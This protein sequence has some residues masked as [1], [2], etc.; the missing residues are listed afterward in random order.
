MGQSILLVV[1]ISQ[2]EEFSTVMKEAGTLCVPLIL[3]WKR[4]EQSVQLWAITEENL[5]KHVSVYIAT[6]LWYILL[7]TS[8]FVGGPNPSLPLKIQCESDHEN[9][10]NCHMLPRNN[11]SQCANTAGVICDGKLQCLL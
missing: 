9:V 10:K 3:D 7:V 5:V 1:V 6:Y 2:E 4:P 8:D 11:I